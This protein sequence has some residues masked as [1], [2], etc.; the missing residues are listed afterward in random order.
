MNIY[1]I[2]NV[3]NTYDVIDLDIVDLAETLSENCE[4]D[5]DTILK[6][7]MHVASDNISLKKM[8][9]KEILCNYFGNSRK[10]GYDITRFG[11][12][13]VLKMNAVEVLYGE[14]SKCG[15]LLPLNVEGNKMMLFNCLTFGKEQEELCVKKYEDG[16]ECG[17]ET[18][19]FNE[20]DI[21]DKA[22]FKSK[23]QHAMSYYCTDKVKLLVEE[24]QLKGIRFDTDLINPF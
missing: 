9:P 22:I 1:Q 10:Q 11:K 5:E 21:E 17:V 7:L 14:L 23:L 13:L 19:Y 8:W 16:F 4:Y 20:N 6:M 18:L 2:K 3:T 12:F 15:E 24:H